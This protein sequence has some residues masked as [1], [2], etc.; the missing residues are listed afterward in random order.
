MNGG[1][2]REAQG[3]LPSGKDKMHH[4]SFHPCHLWSFCLLFLQLDLSSLLFKRY[5]L[6]SQ[7]RIR[8]LERVLGWGGVGGGGARE[9]RGFF[10]FNA[11][12][13]SHCLHSSPRLVY[14]VLCIVWSKSSFLETYCTPVI[15]LMNDR[16]PRCSGLKEESDTYQ[17]LSVQNKRSIQSDTSHDVGTDVRSGSC[18]AQRRGA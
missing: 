9:G 14:P 2:L 12:D 7:N 6:V 1:N 17:I 4:P 3:S 11:C 10:F 15:M 5:L 8:G 18:L 16:R 13:S